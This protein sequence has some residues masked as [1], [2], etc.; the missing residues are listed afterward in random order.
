MSIV[1]INVEHIHN[2]MKP[3]EVLFLTV[4]TDENK[5]VA[6]YLSDLVG[7]CQ[8]PEFTIERL[9]RLCAEK[10]YITVLAA[11]KTGLICHI[12]CD[13]F[14]LFKSEKGQLVNF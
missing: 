2:G 13:A 11:Y 9:A 7:K 14:S 3:N 4:L 6:A 12:K 1:S 5:R 8:L 10:G